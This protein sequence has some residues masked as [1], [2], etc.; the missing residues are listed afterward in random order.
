[1]TA[2]RL[3]DLAVME[4]RLQAVHRYAGECI[5]CGGPDKR[6]RVMDSITGQFHAGDSVAYLSG[7]FDMPVDQV[8]RIIAGCSGWSRA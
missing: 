6:H 4:M 1:M 7:D 5:F 8:E 2:A 3:A